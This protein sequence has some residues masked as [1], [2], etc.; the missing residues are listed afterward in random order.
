MWY[1][2]LSKAIVMLYLVFAA[3]WLPNDMALR[4]GADVAVLVV[5]CLLILT[6]L[7]IH[8]LAFGKVLPGKSWHLDDEKVKYLPLQVGFY[9]V[10][11]F[12]FLNRFIE[13]W[14]QIAFSIAIFI[15]FLGTFL[16][17]AIFKPAL[18]NLHD[19]KIIKPDILPHQRELQSLKSVSYNKIFDLIIFKFANG[20]P[21]TVKY[22]DLGVKQTR[23][24]IREARKNHKGKIR[25]AEKLEKLIG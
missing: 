2:N 17:R 25:I 19:K 20:S 21:I 23:E 14:D 1:L 4:N 10:V 7:G 13:D 3:S 16:L 12:F 15:I 5:G 18:I 24:L 6:L 11:M 22:G 8:W 9:L